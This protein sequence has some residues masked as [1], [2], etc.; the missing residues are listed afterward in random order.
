M[1]ASGEEDDRTTALGS[2]KLLVSGR[3]GQ[4]EPGACGQC[5]LWSP[6]EKLP[7]VL[8]SKPIAA[9]LSLMCATELICE[10]AVIEIFL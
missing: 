1:A 7:P 8:D 4:W 10:P 9:H 6:H 5:W 2:G 3:A